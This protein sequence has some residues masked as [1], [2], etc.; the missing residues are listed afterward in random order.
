M[1][2]D[3]HISMILQFTVNTACVFFLGTRGRAGR[4]EK[5]VEVQQ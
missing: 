1:Q 3:N 2:F 4:E 5:A